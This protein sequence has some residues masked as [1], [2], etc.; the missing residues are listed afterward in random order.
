MIDPAAV[1]AALVAPLAT[2]PVAA[3][4]IGVVGRLFE[5][6][7]GDVPHARLSLLWE[8]NGKAGPALWAAAGMLQILVYVPFGAG[9][10]AATAV[11]MGVAAL[12]HPHLDGPPLDYGVRVVQVAVLD[13]TDLDD[14]SRAGAAAPASWTTVPVQVDF[15]VERVDTGAL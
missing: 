1:R 6:P 2:G 3:A 9:A 11:A 14:R 12:Y 7:A 15:R 10:D 4:H 13:V 8:G 5:P